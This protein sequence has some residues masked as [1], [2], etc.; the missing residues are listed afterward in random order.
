MRPIWKVSH[1]A[2]QVYCSFS[3]PVPLYPSSS[4]QSKYFCLSFKSAEGYSY[5]FS[6]LLVEVGSG[7]RATDLGLQMGDPLIFP[8]PLHRC[9]VWGIVGYL[10]FSHDKTLFPITSYKSKKSIHM[11][12]KEL[13]TNATFTPSSVSNF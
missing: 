5:L 6:N 2:A 9:Q 3:F 13:L 1:V 11:P 10:V 7:T 4:K 8:V 12:C